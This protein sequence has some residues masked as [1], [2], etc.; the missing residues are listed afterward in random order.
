MHVTLDDELLLLCDSCVGNLGV[1]HHALDA[2][3]VGQ[4]ADGLVGIVQHPS[5]SLTEGREVTRHHV[6]SLV[7]TALVSR[8]YY[9]ILLSRLPPALGGRCR[10]PSGRA[11]AE[12]TA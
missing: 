2:V 5:D 7:M 3:K 8:I 12:C 10:T 6:C 11:P 9:D 1:L 4:V